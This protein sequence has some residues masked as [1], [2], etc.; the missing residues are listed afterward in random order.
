MAYVGLQIDAA[1]T[2]LR[3]AT[4]GIYLDMHASSIDQIKS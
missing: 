3:L 4:M 1:V 2:I